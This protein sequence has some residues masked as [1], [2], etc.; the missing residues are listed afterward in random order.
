MRPKCAA[1][2]FVA[3]NNGR[4]RSTE[5]DVLTGSCIE[6]KCRTLHGI[7][8]KYAQHVLS[9][10]TIM[11]AND[12]T[13]HVA[14]ARISHAAAQSLAALGTSRA[15]CCRS[16]WCHFHPNS[17]Q[18]HRHLAGGTSPVSFVAALISSTGSFL[19]KCKYYILPSPCILNCGLRPC[20]QASGHKDGDTITLLQEFIMIYLT[21]A[22]IY[23]GARVVVDCLWDCAP[24]QGI[25]VLRM[26]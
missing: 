20:L 4:I 17:K 9:Q 19:T 8:P 24:P 11:V 1:R 2:T 5:L 23:I 22:I 12:L 6:P 21:A 25:H 15:L 26:Q 10:P 7:R 13:S 16:G 14:G 18:C 3:D